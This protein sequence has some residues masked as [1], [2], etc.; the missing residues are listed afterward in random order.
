MPGESLAGY[1]LNLAHRLDLPPS[2]L[3]RRTGLKTVKRVGI[4][5]LSYSVTLP[6]DV[7]RRFAHATNLTDQQVHA[8]T[9]DSHGPVLNMARPGKRIAR[10]NYGNKWINPGRTRACPQCLSEQTTWRTRWITPWALACTAH[11]TLLIDHCPTCHTPLGEAGPR[12]VR[13]LI[14]HVTVPVEHP[15]A[16]RSTTSRITCNTR[17]D[18]ADAT[19]A[20]PDLLAL[21]ER[22]DGT[23]DS[24]TAD[25]NQWLRDLR[26]VALLLITSGLPQGA[27][28]TPYLAAARDHFQSRP[29]ENADRPRDNSIPPPTSETGAGLLLAANGLLNTAEHADT[30]ADLNHQA[31]RATPTGW[32]QAKNKG[33]PSPLL[34][35]ALNRHKHSTTRPERLSVY[36]PKTPELSADHIAAYLPAD[37]FHAHLADARQPSGTSGQRSRYERPLRRYAAIAVVMHT[38]RVDSL[39]AGSLLD[40]P[41]TLTAA[42]CARA[43]EAFRPLG[44]EPELFRRIGA[45]TA[46]LTDRPRINYRRRRDHMHA[47][48]RIPDDEWRQLQ[49]DLPRANRPWDTRH[50]AFSAWV[51]CLITEGDPLLA[52]MTRIELN[53]RHS[54][55]G[56]RIAHDHHRWGERTLAYLDGLA[57]RLANAID[58]DG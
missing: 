28:P 53:G 2:E 9:V 39:A 45:I 42:A 38:A 56:L 58:S 5:D 50:I 48:W 27:N 43:S 13:S 17:L 52:P 32:E 34:N 29:T 49:A 8:L 6:D 35:E 40:Y 1:V 7:T 20:H 3:I 11:G 24:P 18:Q 36:L 15:T 25:G 16:C 46:D 23:L 21:Q 57:N 10:S 33:G 19:P 51:W 54:T 31:T 14:P 22:L 41:D 30:L 37:L 12:A 26:L 55:T 47:D 44:G 4:L